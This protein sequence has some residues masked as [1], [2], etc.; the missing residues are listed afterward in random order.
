MPLSNRL[1]AEFIGTLWLVLEVRQRR[2]GRCVHGFRSPNT[3]NIA[4]P[5]W[6]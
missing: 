2:A 5:I 4:S 1:A 6:A 3:F